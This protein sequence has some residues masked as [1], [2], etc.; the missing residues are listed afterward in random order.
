MDRYVLVPLDGSL[1][2]EAVLPHAVALAQA[3]GDGLALLRVVAP[4]PLD[5]AGDA[6]AEARAAGAVHAARD[7][8]REV[9]AHLHGSRLVVATAVLDGDPA[10][11]IREQCALDPEIAAVVLARRCAGLPGG[12]TVAAL[13]AAPPVPLLLV[14]AG[15]PP[16]AAY[17]HMLA[18]V[19]CGPPLDGVL[20][21]AR[22]L[23]GAAHGRLVLATTPCRPTPAL[24]AT[25]HEL[26]L[27]QVPTCT[28]LLDG[29]PGAALLR[30]C[31]ALRCDL[32][33]VP[34][35]AAGGAPG[36]AARVAGE[37]PVPVLLVPP[38]AARPARAA[39]L[40]AT[41]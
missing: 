24:P 37:A 12:R 15:A 26:A 13:L 21:L 32:V 3:L 28:L 30:A 6:A 41:A 20:T 36:L 19:T 22:E 18:A 27:Q 35:D 25:I 16:P 29:E 34:A 11:V 1:G 31:T 17:R 5:D 14:P 10:A 40:T 2:A 4:T 7:Y 33:L 9:A 23:A 8:L 39:A 38:D